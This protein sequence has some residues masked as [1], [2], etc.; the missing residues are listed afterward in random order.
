MIDYFHIHTQYPL[1]IV[2][3]ITIHKGHQSRRAKIGL[4]SEFNETRIVTRTLCL[5]FK[6]DFCFLLCG[7]YWL[8]WQQTKV[9]YNHPCF[10]YFCSFLRLILKTGIGFILY[11]IHS[12]KHATISII[13]AGCSILLLWQH[14]K[15]E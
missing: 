13:P 6:I 2:L 1:L 5:L 11:I 14:N 15:F 8:L 12:I 3:H 10:S 4:M 9:L 7:Y